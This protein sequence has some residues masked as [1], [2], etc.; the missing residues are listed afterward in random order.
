MV[1]AFLEASRGGDLERLLQLLDPDAA[2]RVDAAALAMGAQP[3]AGAD[4]VAGHFSGRARAAR[5]VEIDGYA[6]LAW[7]VGGRLNAAF[8]FILDGDRVSELEL[9]VDPEV[10]ATLDVS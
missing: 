8:A 10:L 1:E 5:L 4:A 9:I 2:V 3:L 6:G 7:W